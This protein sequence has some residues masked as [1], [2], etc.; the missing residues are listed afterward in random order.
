M[1]VNRI[2][3]DTHA[4]PIRSRAAHVALFALAIISPA[5]LTAQEPVPESPRCNV[6]DATRRELPFTHEEDADGARFVWFTNC[7][8]GFP[9]SYVPT[10]DVPRSAAFV[11]VDSTTPSGGPRPGD[12]AW[13]P[14]FMGITLMGPHGPLRTPGRLLLIDSLAAR[15]GPPRFFRRRV[16]ARTPSNGGG[17]SRDSDV[18]SRHLFPWDSV[19]VFTRRET[20]DWP[21][22]IRDFGEFSMFVPAASRVTIDRATGNVHLSWPACPACLLSVEVHP[23]AGQDMEA[24]IA[25]LVAQQRTIDSINH[26]PNTVLHEFDVIDGPPQ[27]FRTRTARGYLIR[28]DCGDCAHVSLLLEKPGYVAWVELRAD[29]DVPDLGR[30][31][32]EMTEI[33]TTFTWRGS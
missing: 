27:R 3:T 7:R 22:A 31:V 24:R 16:D 1:P 20:A 9:Y 32:I 23:A 14:T 33:G 29:D 26:D 15:L 25:Q 30:H 4:A 18:G 5:L 28:E 13:W 10:A 2:P 21:G 12:V 19:P 8:A 6:R 17:G 11:E